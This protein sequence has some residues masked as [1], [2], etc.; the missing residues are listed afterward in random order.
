MTEERKDNEKEYSNRKVEGDNI[1][2]A[3]ICDEIAD[4]SLM[5]NPSEAVYWRKKA[6]EHIENQYGKNHIASIVYYDKLVQ[7]LLEKG[8]FRQAMKWNEKARKIKKKE[9]G[10]YALDT[11]KN[12]LYEVEIADCLFVQEKVNEDEAAAKSMI[13]IKE[14]L[15]KNMVDDKTM[16]YKIYSELSGWIHRKFDMEG[17]ESIRTYFANQAICL[18]QELY[19]EESYEVIEAY[20][21]KALGIRYLAGG[22]KENE[23][24]LEYFRKALLIAS[25]KGPSGFHVTK[26]ILSLLEYCWKPAEQKE[27]YFNW[28]S[29]NISEQFAKEMLT[30]LSYEEIR[31]MFG[32]D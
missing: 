6:I 11:V 7:D 3:A 9:L 28:V 29:E 10:E 18:A 8:S 22:D 30:P 21:Q 13:H 32:L 4:N 31:K 2:N 19:G 1:K 24:A 16:L 12:D 27:K 17:A 23:E 15:D 20:L 25:Q 26:R 5:G 14:C